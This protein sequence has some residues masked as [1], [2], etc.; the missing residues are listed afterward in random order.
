MFKLGALSDLESRDFPGFFTIRSLVMMID[1]SLHRPFFS[2][3][4][5]NVALG[6]S[7]ETNWH[8][9]QRGVMKIEDYHRKVEEIDGKDEDDE[10][11]EEAYEYET[12]EELEHEYQRQIYL[13]ERKNKQQRQTK[14]TGV[15]F[16]VDY[17]YFARHFFPGARKYHIAKVTEHLC[18]T[19]IFSVIK[20]SVESHTYRGGY[21]PEK[22]YLEASQLPLNTAEK[23]AIYEIFCQYERWKARVMGY[24]F[25]DFVN[26]VLRQI[27]YNRHKEISLHYLQVDEIQDLPK[28]VVYLL[29]Q[30]VEQGVFFSGDTA[31]TIAKGI[32]FRFSDL[33]D[34]FRNHLPGL[35]K[36]TTMQLTVNFRSHNS[37]LQ[38]ANSVV[39]VLE[40]FFPKSID[41]LRKERSNL[42][43]PRPVLVDHSDI[44]VLFMLLSDQS[45]AQPS[46][47]IAA[48]PRLEFGCDQV[49]IV[50]D[51]A[52]KEKVPRL[53]Q[54][55]LCLTIYEAKG[56]EFEDVILLN[57]FSSCPVHA[58]WGLLKH[59]NISE[60]QVDIDFYRASL[61]KL[62]SEDEDGLSGVRVE[63]EKVFLSKVKA[64]G[65]QPDLRDC[66][67]LAAELKLLYTAITR[68]RNTLIIYDENMDKRRAIEKYWQQLGLIDIISL[69][70]LED[71]S[72]RG[73]QEIKQR[74]FRVKGT[75]KEA[76][77]AQGLRMFK[78]KYFEQAVKCF[79]HSG[80]QEMHDKSWAYM[81]AEEASRIF[82]QNE[83]ERNS[84]HLHENK[85][86][87][88]AIK[89]QI[90]QQ[91]EKAVSTF[92]QAGAMF[93]TLGMFKE[94]GKC[95]FSG[96]ELPL[97]KELFLKAG[98]LRE[99][100][101]CCYVLNQFKEAAA[102][103]D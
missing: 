13:L 27:R 31:Q 71:G 35:A 18:W 93:N 59:L 79:S 78:R 100:A 23:M 91:H 12:E 3:N 86:Q 46:K 67:E 77:H 98:R 87:V 17:D 69:E 38:L 36:P 84:L 64:D 49:I 2:R 74:I 5:H 92:R 76:W 53:L 63:G 99:A 34:L 28:S 103:Y 32:N 73:H 20:G 25:M 60:E 39:S 40:Q 47:D 75:S 41:R 8:N 94:A 11:L 14:K 29:C 90:K 83:T 70:G 4:K 102:L 68:P 45:R 55:A 80:H 95:Y 44:E 24:D 62:S 96:K 37:I 56:L 16:E 9:E 33:T 6:T 50:R 26:Y 101:E 61:S 85:N 88:K 22:V 58:S 15:S 19:E 81:M 52:E 43:G 48:R 66:S 65:K 10:E 21:L 54:H 57:F 30:V 89:K 72:L 7:K 51:Q 82:I 1:G 42:Q 97:A